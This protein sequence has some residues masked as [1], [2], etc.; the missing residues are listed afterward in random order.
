MSQMPESKM[1]MKLNPDGVVFY[2]KIEPE[3]EPEKKV[4]KLGPIEE[5]APVV[6]TERPVIPWLNKAKHGSV[7]PAKRRSVKQMMFDQFVQF[8]AHVLCPGKKNNTIYPHN[9]P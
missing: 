8:I 1:V 7:I 6:G 9:N 3:P 4:M 2:T 5:L